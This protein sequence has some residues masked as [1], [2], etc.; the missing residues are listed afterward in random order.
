MCLGPV[1]AAW[2]CPFCG[3]ANAVDDNRSS[4]FELSILFMLGMP[5]LLAG[6]FGFGFYRLSRKAAALQPT[7]NP[8][9]EPA[10]T[11]APALS[12]SSPA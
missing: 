8:M 9:E 2:A 12:T 3:E 7:E 1:S 4:A 11:A 5:I 6:A 10:R